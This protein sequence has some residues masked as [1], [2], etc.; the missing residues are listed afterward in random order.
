MTYTTLV[1]TETAFQHLADPGWI[2]I[3]CRFT[4]T[5]PEVGH[6]AWHRG[7]IPG[8]RYA[9]L[10]NDLSAPKSATTGRHPLPAP[11]S[12]A[13]RLSAWGVDEA[14]Q[15][16]VYDDSFGAMAGRLWWLLRWLGHEAV[17]LLDGGIQRWQKEGRPLD[18]MAP[19]ITP[20]HFV[21]RPNPAL[22]V[23]A[24]EVM[25]ATAEP[26]RLLLDARS[27]ERFLG[28]IEPLDKVA[29]HIPGSR[30]R[31]FEDN[32][33]LGGTF[34]SPEELRESYLEQLGK[35][36]P[37]HVIHLCGSGV[38]ACHNVLAMEAAGLKGSKLYI[39]S[40]SEWITDPARPVATGPEPA[41]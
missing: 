5:N 16:V 23:D 10:D 11:G 25:A 6:V 3:D 9:H 22:L 14:K 33:D 1:D 18:S 17:A 19:Q 41:P 20:A 13:D 2:F 37:G 35:T 40:W 34:L 24:A 32:L 28:E 12:L 39:G 38:T 15:V 4:L 26:G 27:E 30:N 21:A 36:T 8:A 29:G 31:P 7:H